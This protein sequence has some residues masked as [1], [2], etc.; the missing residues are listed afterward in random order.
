MNKE[1]FLGYLEA[2]QDIADNEN[3]FTVEDIPNILGDIIEKAEQL[4]LTNQPNW[5]PWITWTNDSKITTV[6]SKTNI[7]ISNNEDWKVTHLPN[8]DFKIEY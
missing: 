1:R 6:S 5:Y 2:L 3:I 4:E 7:P 8:G